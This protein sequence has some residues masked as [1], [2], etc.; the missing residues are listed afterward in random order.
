V[1]DREH[2]GSSQGGKTKAE[3]LAGQ[4]QLG[5][6]SSLS[7]SSI[8]SQRAIVS[9]FLATTRELLRAGGKAGAETGPLIPFQMD[10]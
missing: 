1:I 6:S 7:H 5:W 10:P 4:K 8:N 2:G 3:T 9:K